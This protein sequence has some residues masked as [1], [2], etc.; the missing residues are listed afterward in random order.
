MIVFLF[1]RVEQYLD[2]LGG[3]FPPHYEFFSITFLSEECLQC[4]R[5]L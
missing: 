4:A 5:I 3:A 1:A 2:E